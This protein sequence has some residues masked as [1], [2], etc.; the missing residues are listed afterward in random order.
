MTRSLERT[1]DYVSGDTTWTVSL[2]ITAPGPVGTVWSVSV[3]GEVATYTTVFGDTTSL[4]AAGIKLAVDA[5]DHANAGF[6]GSTVSI[7][8]DVDATCGFDSDW[9]SASW[10]ATEGRTLTITAPG[11][12]GVIWTA[13]VLGLVA[14]YTVQ[15]ADTATLVATGLNAAIDALAGVT[16]TRSGAVCTVTYAAPTDLAQRLVV[17]NN[18]AGTSTNVAVAGPASTRTIAPTDG[19]PGAHGVYGSV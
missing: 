8:T 11:A 6:I 10:V 17:T 12:T 15:A 3:A 1:R 9:G 19:T 14:T 18:G 4:V 2:L 5:L 16:S 7:T 13:N